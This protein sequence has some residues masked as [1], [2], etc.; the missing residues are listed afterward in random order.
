MHIIRIGYTVPFP[1]P[2]RARCPMTPSIRASIIVVV[3]LV[4]CAAH[5]QEPPTEPETLEPVIVTATLEDRR[6]D[7]A[8]VSATVLTEQEIRDRRID[9]LRGIDDHVPNVQFNQIGQIG[10][11]Y[12]TI[13]GIES[14]PFIVNR[15]AVY[16][17]GIPFRR[18]RDQAL[19][20]VEQIEVLRGPQGT[21]YGAN[22]ESGLVLIRTRTPGD[23]TAF[24]ATG[25]A[26]DFANGRGY[27]FRATGGGAVVPGVLAATVTASHDDADSF[28]RNVASSIGEPGSV[29]ESLLQAKFRL[30]PGD[31]TEL[32]AVLSWSDLEAPGLYEQE[33]LPIGRDVYDARYRDIFNAGRRARPYEL[34][35]DAP[36]RTDESERMAGVS[37]RHDAGSLV[38]NAALSWRDLEGRSFGTDL[39]LTALPAAAGG[40]LDDTRATSA[41]L[42]VASDD[43]SAL[44]W[45]L[46]FS[47]YRDSETQVLASLAGPGG[48]D[49]YRPAPP[50]RSRALDRALFGQLTVPLAATVDFTAGLRYERAERRKRQDAGVLDLGAVGQFRFDAESLEDTYDEV[51]PKLTLGWTPDSRTYFY[52]SSAKG[53]IP[54]GFN[55]QAV[56]A[57]LASGRDFSR[58]GPETLWSHELGGKWSLFDGRA[59]ASVALFWIEADGWQEYN[60]LTDASGRAISTNLITNDAALRSRG[61]EAEFTWRPGAEWDVAASLGLVDSR[62]R[63]YRF[64]AQQ[65]FGGNR[66]KLVP[67][68]DA[69]LSA[70]WRPG[71]GFYARGEVESLGRTPLDAGNTVFQGATTLLNLQVGWEA[72]RWS[73]RLF[74][75]NLTDRLVYTSS[76]YT[77]FAFGADG[78][79]YAAV[80]RPRIVGVEWVAYW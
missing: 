14:N 6:L 78:T 61:A 68:F 18:L 38:W 77:N 72:D 4:P 58:Y 53:W 22:T 29:A 47:Q 26:S 11:T 31:A 21:L 23:D 52:A 13:R 9:R 2:G 76:A 8:P 27:G 48:L 63:R 24:E 71:N 60:V 40:D 19:G 46:G 44:R 55:L 65:D 57:T 25:E 45:V 42:R 50:Q 41:E 54:G 66:T 73:A 3:A 39:D 75:D 64:T 28:V 34:I 74:V 33:F 80:G 20:S 30:T 7:Q 16:I 12:L 35:N 17:D 56:S 67:R 59:L 15:A 37:W 43:E 10:G 51:L 49:D 1:H 70:S 5:A 69:S 79:A 36:K 62:Y 32:N